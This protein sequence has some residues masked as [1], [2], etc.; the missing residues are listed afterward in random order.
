MV[1]PPSVAVHR[2]LA[3]AERYWSQID[4]EAASRGADPITLPIDR[5]CNLIEW[6][7]TQRVRDVDRFLDDLYRPLPGQPVTAEDIDRDA[8]NFM[9]FAAAFGVAPPSQPPAEATA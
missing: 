1:R 3:Y 9:A 8:E 6:W 5:F 7:V 4:G 2:L